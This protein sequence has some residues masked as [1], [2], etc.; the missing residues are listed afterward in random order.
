MAD[1]R[2]ICV[3][4]IAGAHGVRGSV[5]LRSFTE[6]PEAVGSY[7][8][9]MDEEGRKFSIRLQ[10]V[11]KDHFIAS[12]EGVKD[13]DEAEAL[14]GTKLFVSRA[15]LPKLKPR[16]YYEADLVGL[17]VEDKAGVACGK[18]QAVHNYGGGP[19][20]EIAPAKG[21]TYMLPFTKAYVPEV[22]IKAGRVVIDPPEGW[23]GEPKPAKK[24]K[25]KVA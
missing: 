25:G 3:G 17:P 1:D 23:V 22:D 16:E 4:V 13:R 19:F 15:A 6:D 18:V 2:K 20:L 7:G 9:L 24:G 12:I 21:G 14:K 5:R 8:P 11:M 10:G